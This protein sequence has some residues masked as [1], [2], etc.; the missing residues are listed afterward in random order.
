MKKGKRQSGGFHA[1][2]VFYVVES[3]KQRV[4]TCLP[5]ASA[6]GRGA[7]E[8]VVAQRAVQIVIYILSEVTEAYVIFGNLNFL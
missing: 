1:E 3:F 8:A 2:V 5:S 6:S 4:Q 7:E